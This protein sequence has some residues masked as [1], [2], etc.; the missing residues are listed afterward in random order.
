MRVAQIVFLY[1]VRRRVLVKYSDEL[2]YCPASLT[3][4]DVEVDAGVY[5]RSLFIER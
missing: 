2:S 1:D 3:M 5:A 4:S